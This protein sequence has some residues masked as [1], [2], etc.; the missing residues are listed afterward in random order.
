LSKKS[1]SRYIDLRKK[2]QHNVRMTRGERENEGNMEI[3]LETSVEPD[4]GARRVK[5]LL[6]QGLREGG[7]R[8]R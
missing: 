3:K 8:R 2:G 4:Q 1:V 5:I 7:L 6:L